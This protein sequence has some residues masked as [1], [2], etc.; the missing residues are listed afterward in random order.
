MSGKNQGKGSEI[1]GLAGGSKD[2][3]KKAGSQ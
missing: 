3:R 2:K 1:N